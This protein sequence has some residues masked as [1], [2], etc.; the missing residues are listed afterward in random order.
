MQFVFLFPGQGSQSVGMA[1][2]L[3]EEYEL[4]QDTFDQASQALGYSMEELV[5]EGPEERLT[6]TQFTQPA[7]LTV[8]VAISRVLVSKGI[9]PVMSAGHSLGEYASLVLG[10]AISFVSALKLVEMRGRYMQEAVPLGEGT[11]AAALGCDDDLLIE[12]VCHEVSRDGYVV[13]AANFNCP[14]QVVISGHVGAVHEACE[15]LKQKGVRRCI[16]LNV[17]A[18][19]HSSLLKSAGDQLDRELS[20]ID[21]KKPK[22]PYFANVDVEE[23]KQADQ[24]RNRLAMQVWKPVRWSQTLQKLV[25][26][27]PQGT[28][29]EVGPGAVVSGHMKKVSK[30]VVCLSTHNTMALGEVLA[31][32]ESA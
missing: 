26:L 3:Y 30:D 8:E 6:Q 10:Q 17:S 20:L 15:R 12:Q 13:E 28:F 5:F 27:Y 18:P 11:M 1:K 16:P 9:V 22:I 24:I 14:G 29:V 23:I 25:S 21:V 4:V 32:I 2:M 7:I 31:L 19:F